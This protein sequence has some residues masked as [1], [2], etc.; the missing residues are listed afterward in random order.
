VGERRVRRFAAGPGTPGAR[1]GESWCKATATGGPARPGRATGA[2]VEIQ[3]LR[4]ASSVGGTIGATSRPRGGG[5]TLRSCCGRG[6]RSR[7][8]PT[9]GRDSSSSDCSGHLAAGA[10]GVAGPIEDVVAGR[11]IR[12]RT[13]ASAT[14]LTRPD[15]LGRSGAGAGA[16]AWRHLNTP[17]GESQL[18]QM[19]TSCPS[20][21][22]TNRN[23]SRQCW[24]MFRL[25]NGH[26]LRP[27]GTLTKP[28]SHAESKR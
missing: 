24:Q 9:T 17:E 5:P 23:C 21:E 19:T 8:R 28:S 22:S 15:E 4:A 11:V 14:P 27:T 6:T 3:L 2:P 20:R 10:V 26:G 7:S 25:R 12:R 13:T 18:G 1:R 16:L